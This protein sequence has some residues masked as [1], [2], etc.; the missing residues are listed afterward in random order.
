MASSY[1]YE[2]SRQTGMLA[3]LTSTL[4]KHGLRDDMWV[5]RGPGSMYMTILRSASWTTFP[6]TLIQAPAWR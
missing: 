6:M 3:Q 1:M 4:R 5:R 2:A